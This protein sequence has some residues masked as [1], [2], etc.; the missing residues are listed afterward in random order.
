[1]QIHVLQRSTIFFRSTRPEVFCKKGVL[2]NFTKFS[3]KHLSQSLF[4]NIV[5]GRRPATLLKKILWHRCFPLNFVKFLRTPFYIEHFRWLCLI[6]VDHQ[7]CLFRS[8]EESGSCVLDVLISKYLTKEKYLTEQNRKLKT[9]SI[10][11]E[12]YKNSQ[13]H[14]FLHRTIFFKKKFGIKNFSFSSFSSCL[15][16]TL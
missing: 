5:A 4:F 1:M 11:I 16:V 10:Y 9:M 13:K 7:H 12:T 8:Q 3:G 2:K 6:F 14:E 15:N